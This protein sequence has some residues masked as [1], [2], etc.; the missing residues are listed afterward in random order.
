MALLPAAQGKTVVGSGDENGVNL[1]PLYR[2][3]AA[4]RTAPASTTAIKWYTAATLLFAAMCLASAAQAKSP[5][6]SFADLAEKL[7]PAVVNIATTQ[8]VQQS[9]PPSEQQRPQFP[10]GSPFEDFFK[11]FFDRNQPKGGGKPRRANALGSGFII[12]PSGIVITNNH[13]IAEA[14]EI[15]I[16]MQDDTEYTAELLG[17]DPK[18]DLAVLKIDPGNKTLPY[19]KFGDS[20]A[21]RVGDWVVAIGNPFGLGGTVTAGIISARGRDLQ[22]PYDDFIQTDASI[23]RG[24]SGGPLFN[25]QGEVVGINTA[26]FS[27]SGGSVG[28]G[29]AV[30]SRLAQPVIAQL[31]EFGRTRRGWLGVFIQGVTDEIAES[32]GLPKAE[33]ALVSNITKDGPAEAAGLEK[34]DVILSFNNEK[35]ANMRQLPRIVAGTPIGK[36]VPVVVWR[37]GQKV[38]VQAKIGELEAAEKAQLVPASRRQPPDRAETGQIDSLGLDLSMITDLLRQKFNIEKTA[39]GVVITDVAA[40]SVAGAKGLEVGDVIVEV[41]QN[42]VVKP[43]DVAKSVNEARE[44][45][46]KSVLMLISRRGEMRFVALRFKQG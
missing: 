9:G 33:G 35:V 42:E 17:R 15:K 29:F 26:I 23:N 24:N 2:P 38:T 45:K 20:D 11:D 39:K 12:D 21:A 31:Q 36:A 41:N 28:I 40:D 34:G 4:V 7:L 25:L 30:S 3:L 6:D 44:K 37:N 13:V 22:G 10:P 43:S 5:P 27:Q 32:L 1:M 46:L 19:V 14:D 18:T 16:I 8:Q